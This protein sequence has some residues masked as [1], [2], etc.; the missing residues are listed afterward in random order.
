LPQVLAFVAHVVTEQRQQAESAE[1]DGEENV[2][3]VSSPIV[4][5]GI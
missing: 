1:D 5:S 4:E 3:T 2:D